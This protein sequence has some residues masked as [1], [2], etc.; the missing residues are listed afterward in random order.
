MLFETCK[1]CGKTWG[2]TM[3]PR[4]DIR[5]SDCL[6]RP[7]LYPVHYWAARRASLSYM[8]GPSLKF[9]SPQYHDWWTS[10][11]DLAYAADLAEQTWGG[12][13]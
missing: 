8:V 12:E 9:R 11:E 3:T 1:H 10:M 4:A 6:R 2:V 7:D 13:S 5:C